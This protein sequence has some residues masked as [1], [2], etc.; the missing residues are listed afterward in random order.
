MQG[1][2][3]VQDA[4]LHLSNRDIYYSDERKGIFLCENAFPGKAGYASYRIYHHESGAVVKAVYEHLIGTL[5]KV[6]SA[7]TIS[8]DF[9]IDMEMLAQE[10]I[11]ELSK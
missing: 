1:S 8:T 10:A 5:K 4:L 2:I 11:K 3:Q 9:I 7:S 6:V